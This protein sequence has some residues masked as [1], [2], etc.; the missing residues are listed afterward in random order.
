M[1]EII[2]QDHVSRVREFGTVD[3]CQVWKALAK[4]KGKF[5]AYQEDIAKGDICKSMGPLK[6][7]KKI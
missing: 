5:P 3:Q 1:T 4:F 7:H 2:D 6:L